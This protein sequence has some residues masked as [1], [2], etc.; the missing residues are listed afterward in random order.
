MKKVLVFLAVIA[1]VMS[2][3]V[4]ASAAGFTESVNNKPA[5]PVE[6]VPD[7]NGQPALGIIRDPNGKIVGY[8][9]ED[10]LVITPVSEADTSDKIPE[11]AKNLLLDIYAKLTSG[12]MK[13]P[14]EQYNPEMNSGNMV[15][16]DLFDASFLCQ[17]HPALLAQDGYTLELSF[18]LG[19]AAGEEVVTM[20]YVNGQ[21]KPV[22]TVNN[23]D[24]T[25]TCVFD[26]ICPIA[27]SVRTDAS[28]P[29]KT[30]D[31]SMMPWLI[32]GSVALLAL[33]AVVVIYHVNSK[34]H[35]A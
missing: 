20:V 9:Y 11:A 16:R 33:V 7:G 25:V 24:G 10:C 31:I 3:C 21:W 17:D 18:N 5:P 30:G 13:L 2:M 1:M 14:Y 28:T 35:G 6:E 22:S 32:L 12:E 27:F 4:A 23:G 8:V 34:K 19:V 26:E 29:E 15:I